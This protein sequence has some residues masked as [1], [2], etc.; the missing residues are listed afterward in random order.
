M[1]NTNSL[2]KKP[3]KT[4]SL[5][6]DSLPVTT[7]KS[8]TTSSKSHNTGDHQ[9]S[10][11]NENANSKPLAIK[12]SVSKQAIS[13]TL[14]SDLAKPANLAKTAASPKHISSEV[15]AAPTNTNLKKAAKQPAKK[16][17]NSTSIGSSMNTAA[18]S[19][20]SGVNGSNNATNI[21]AHVSAAISNGAIS[22]AASTKTKTSLTK[23]NSTTQIDQIRVASNTITKRTNKKP[24]A[25]DLGNANRIEYK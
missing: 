15:A 8:E 17:T 18:T 7:T 16:L 1:A 25:A 12:K 9:H 21:V 24:A 14:N 20:L 22:S 13:N 3:L 23:T 6:N 4:I 10:A 19:M 11:T 5:N 2:F